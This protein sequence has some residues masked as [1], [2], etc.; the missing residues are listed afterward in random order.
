MRST[1]A[2][3]SDLPETKCRIE[4]SMGQ[5][6]QYQTISYHTQYSSCLDRDSDSGFPYKMKNL[7]GTI[8][9]F[10]LI[11]RYNA[12]YF[13]IK[14]S[15]SNAFPATPGRS[16]PFQRLDLVSCQSF[17]IENQFLSQSNNLT[18]TSANKSIKWE[19]LQKKRSKIFSIFIQRFLW[20][21][22][23]KKK[24]NCHLSGW[25]KLTESCL[26]LACRV[27]PLGTVVYTGS[28][29]IPE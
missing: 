19:L 21:I 23:S 6:G 28:T 26:Y 7:T 16:I 13:P 17:S 29:R 12:K 24:N 15:S 14:N 25:I 8:F 11:M 10:R 1:M 22:K 2:A 9:Q 27:W 18:I 3:G 4:D 20:R 5:F